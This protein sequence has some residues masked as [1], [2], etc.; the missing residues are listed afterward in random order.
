MHFNLK[1]SP[2]SARTL[3]PEVGLYL[4]SRNPE[5]LY[6]VSGAAPLHQ[7]PFF[8]LQ[9]GQSWEQLLVQVKSD[10][11]IENSSHRLIGV[12]A[13]RNSTAP[14]RA[15]CVFQVTGWPH[16]LPGGL[17]W[18]DLRHNKSAD[19]VTNRIV[20]GFSLN[21]FTVWVD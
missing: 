2:L 13:R 8:S 12:S 16:T 21:S 5:G 17:V 3:F 4:V 6:L 20:E 11:K 15:Y 1:E 10:W 14:G 9:G 18:K 7:I 19:D